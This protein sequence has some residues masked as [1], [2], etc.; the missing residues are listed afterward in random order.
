V[1]RL[2]VST[3]DGDFVLNHGELLVTGDLLLWWDEPRQRLVVEPKVVIRFD[4]QAMERAI[5][6]ARFSENEPD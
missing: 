6:D 3:E 2:T 4:R 1:R 5:L